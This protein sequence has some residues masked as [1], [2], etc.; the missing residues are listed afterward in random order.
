MFSRTA[1]TGGARRTTVA[2]TAAAPLPPSPV[3]LFGSFL[4]AR[5]DRFGGAL[6]PALPTQL[7]GGGRVARREIHPSRCFHRLRLGAEICS[8]VSGGGESAPASC[9]S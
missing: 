5:G 3:P 9:R 6:V 8:P 7:R 1:V 2:R 4:S